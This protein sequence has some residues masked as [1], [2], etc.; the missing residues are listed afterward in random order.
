MKRIAVVACTGGAGHLRAA[1]ALVAAA[2]RSRLPI[3]VASWDVLSFTPPWFRRLYA[4]S[5][6]EAVNRAPELWGFFYERSERH[7]H[8]NPAFIRAFDR[9]NYLPYWRALQDFRPDA[10]VC[11]HFLPYLSIAPRLSRERR[12]PL[13]AAVTT[14]FDVHRL[15]ID[16]IVDRYF[17]FHEETRFLLTA[18]GVDE[19]RIAVSGIPVMPEFATRTRG[20]VARREL[21]LSPHR[22]TVLVVAGGFGMGKIVDIAKAAAD[23]LGS[24]RGL[25]SQL[26]VVCGRNASALD[27]VRRLPVRSNVDLRAL[28]FVQNMHD[29]MDA[30]D[31]LVSKSGGL[32]SSEA[33]AKGL[34]MLIVDPIPGQE[35]RNA[36]LIADH[37]AGWKATS[38][39]HL[40]FKLQ[41]LLNEPA[42]LQRAARHARRLGC[43]R[44]AQN[45][46]FDVVERLRVPSRATASGH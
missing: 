24:I 44:A 23:T 22:R 14:D 35:S 28:G 37:G 17:V 11:T 2:R 42:E 4:G 20:D 31:L 6:L 27:R 25:R 19:E 38:L 34:P 13:I 10:L 36:D 33:L 21:G 12:P 39:D 18:K 30:A 26:V 40:R 7:P 15:W 3:E 43:P 46:L 1:E 29:W 5:Y 32:T 9:V 45:I 8:H 16:P 41:R